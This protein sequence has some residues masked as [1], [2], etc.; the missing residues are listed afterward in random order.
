MTNHLLRLL[1]VILLGLGG[2]Y[3]Y[4]SQQ[5]QQEQVDGPLL[6]G[7]M[8]HGTEIN[9]IS[10]AR[11]GQPALNFSQR[12]QQWWA[13]SLEYPAAQDKLADLLLGLSEAR[14]EEAKS[15]RQDQYYRLGVQDINDEGSEATLVGLYSDDAN[16]QVLL[17]KRA[18]AGVGMYA[19]LPTAKQSYLIDQQISLPTSAE[20]WLDKHLLAADFALSQ[21]ARIGEGGWQI[22]LQENQA[23]LLSQPD[24]AQL[25]YPTIAQTVFDSVGNLQFS[26]FASGWPD[27]AEVTE[28]SLIAADGRQQLWRFATTEQ[29]VVLEISGDVQA[30]QQGRYFV[31]NDVALQSLLQ[32]SQDFFTE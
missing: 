2:Y 22:A 6:Q 18:S 26:E 7:L 31:V 3:L 4:T 30:Y 15:A 27:G 24:N 25:K 17:G 1:A 5:T 14:L 29:Q 32:P 23:V 16:W 19:R 21:L 10:L 20:E 28:L 11:H 13:D 9:R 12:G 8:L